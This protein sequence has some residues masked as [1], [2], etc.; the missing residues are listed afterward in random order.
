ML[1]NLAERQ[2]LFV[3]TMDVVNDNLINAHDFSH[4][5]V[6]LKSVMSQDQILQ[7]VLF[8]QFLPIV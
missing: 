5:G 2:T 8:S 4:N 6:L 1:L 7:S 3:T